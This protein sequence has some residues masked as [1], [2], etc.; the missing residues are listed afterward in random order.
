M[1]DTDCDLLRVNVPVGFL[2]SAPQEIMVS[3]N[4]PT[5]HPL[6]I[7]LRLIPAE[8]PDPPRAQSSFRT[9]RRLVACGIDEGFP[10]TEY[11]YGGGD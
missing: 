7:R 3:V 5:E 1:C 4:R 10:P 11:D 9:N 8:P 6:A 2:L